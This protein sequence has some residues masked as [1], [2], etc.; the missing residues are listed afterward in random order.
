M[1][2]QQVRDKILNSSEPLIIKQ[3]IKWNILNWSLEDWKNLLQN[4]EMEFRLGSY[5]PTKEPQWERYTDTI[6]GKFDFFLNQ[7]QNDLKKWLYF[8]YKYLKTNLLNATELRN[9]QHLFFKSNVVILHHI[10]AGHNIG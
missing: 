1:N 7:T 6:K 9:V 4:E 2:S 5:E 10:F 8:D 3:T